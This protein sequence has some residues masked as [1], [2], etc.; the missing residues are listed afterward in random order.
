MAPPGCNELPTTW[1][2]QLIAKSKITLGIPSAE[3][4]LLR[5]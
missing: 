4:L 5:N 1:H 3:S 2:R